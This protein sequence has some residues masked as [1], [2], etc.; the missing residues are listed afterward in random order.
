M[1]VSATVSFWRWLTGQPLPLESSPTAEK[2]A[3]ERRIWLRHAAS[4]SIRC[5]EAGSEEQIGVSAVLSDISRGGIQLIASR[6]FEPGTLLSVELPSARDEDGMA[7]LACVIRATPHGENEWKMGCRFSSELDD[8]QLNALG[9][10]R[11]RPAES[12]PRSWERFPCNTKAFYQRVNDPVGPHHPARVLNIASGGMAL[13]V[14]EPVDVGD[15]L[16][17]DLHNAHGQPIMT[18]LACVVHSQNVPEGQILG[19]HF[20]RELSDADIKALV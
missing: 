13:M 1:L 2:T 10:S 19:C 9:A 20:I 14:Q 11:T 12:D 15:L 4:I 8:G 16:S 17:T 3:E 5:G 7:V 6:R 18:I